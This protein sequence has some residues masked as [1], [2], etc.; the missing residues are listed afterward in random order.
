MLTCNAVGDIIA[1][2]ELLLNVARA[3]KEVKKAP[4]EYRRFCAELD[5]LSTV[6]SAAAQMS[7]GTSS[8]E[9]LPATLLEVNRCML[10]VQVALDYIAKFSPLDSDEIAN[11]PLRVKLKRQWYKLEWRFATRATA[12]E[13]GSRIAASIQRLTAY[14][15]ISNAGVLANFR[16][17]FEDQFDAYTTFL[18]MVLFEHFANVA[19][20]QA[21][22]RRALATG[23]TAILDEL[24][25]ISQSDAFPQ[26]VNSH[27]AAAV[28]VLVAAICTRNETSDAVHTTLLATA[29]GILLHGMTLSRHP[30]QTATAS[31]AAPIWEISEDQ[32]T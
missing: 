10:D 16:A 1:I 15:V 12:Q 21:A 29:V 20:Q 32:E 26:G 24:R 2:A 11:A 9:L 27:M 4:A 22:L 30:S 7:E 8:A 31:G 17:A 18:C 23:N 6:L 14:I 19:A 13:A 25:A 3:L 5:S 28:A